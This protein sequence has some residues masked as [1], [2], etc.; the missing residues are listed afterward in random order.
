M[1]RCRSDLLDCSG[2]E[3]AM[4]MIIKHVFHA[5]TPTNR[6]ARVTE[7]VLEQAKVLCHDWS[8]NGK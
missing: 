8:G 5:P 1:A 2:D 3:W 4:R 7:V 6:E